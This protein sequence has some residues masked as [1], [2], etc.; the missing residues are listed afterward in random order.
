[1]VQCAGLCAY[2]R[3][4]DKGG[5]LR[6]AFCSYLLYKF[7]ARMYFVRVS[8]IWSREGR[9][10]TIRVWERMECAM[11]NHGSPPAS[12]AGLQDRIRRKIGVC[13]AEIPSLREQS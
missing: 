8:D 13:G 3:R 7:N 9:P 5:W 10:I 11:G 2:R 1:M 12:C 4:V 6:A